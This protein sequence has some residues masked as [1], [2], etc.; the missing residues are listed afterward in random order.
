MSLLAAL[1]FLTAIPLPG[2]QYSPEVVGRSTAYFPVIGLIIGLIMAGWRFLLVLLLPAPVAN[3]LVI[4]SLVVITG[5]L[6]LDGF[7][8]TCDGLAAHRT[9]AERWQ[10]M[11]DSR[12]GGF[13]VI[14][15]S[16]LLLV[17]YI[18]LTNVPSSLLTVTL[19]LAPVLSRWAMVY[20]IFVYPYAR[21]SGLGTVFKERTTWQ[22]FTIAT[23]ITLAISWIVLQMTGI[24]VMMG[25]WV[26]VVIV[27]TYLKNK[28]AGLTGDTYG[29]INEIAETLVFILIIV[30]A[31]FGLA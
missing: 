17:K 25:I 6:H 23:V 10:V 14:G 16:A 19:V 7:V 2:R 29:A 13:G 22:R 24:A 5:A 8:D 18:S 21:P 26:T 4:A 9:V 1:Q 3:V 27:A 30:L 11:R 31:R 28:F 15:V 12:A 20:A